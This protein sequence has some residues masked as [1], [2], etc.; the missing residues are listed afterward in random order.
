MI[1]NIQILFCFDFSGLLRAK[2]EKAEGN[3]KLIELKQ[4]QSGSNLHQVGV[5]SSYA[6]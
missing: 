4:M 1:I 5:L 3:K 6:F 2:V